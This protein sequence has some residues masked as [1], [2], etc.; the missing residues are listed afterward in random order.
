[1]K[2]NDDSDRIILQINATD[3]RVVIFSDSHLTDNFDELKFNVFI[4]I[5]DQAD[6]VVINGDFWDGFQIEY[7]KFI[8]SDWQKLFKLL[9][10][11]NTYYLYGNHDPESYGDGKEFSN[12]QGHV[13]KLNQNGVHFHIEHGNRIYPTIDERIKIPRFIR[14]LGNIFEGL[15][16]KLF[17]RRLLNIYI[18]DN[19]AMK[20]WKMDNLDKNEWL[21]CG[22]SH[23]KELSYENKFI[24]EGLINWGIASYSMIV[25]GKA[26]L[27]EFTY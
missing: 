15:S 25:N 19:L 23:L 1:M 8:R 26:E 13:L 3:K 6:I 16:I 11:K 22:H 27:K 4:K 14:G 9:L 7:K 5:I 24:N 21:I 18:K 10:V 2:K 20:K 17:G 12:Y